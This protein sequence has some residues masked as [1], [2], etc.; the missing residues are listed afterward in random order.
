VTGSEVRKLS[1]EE[2]VKWIGDLRRE[3]DD[4]RV[5]QVTQKIEDNSR[6]GKNRRDLARLLTEQTARR[7]R[8]ETSD[9]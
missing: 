5:Q 8:Q 7:R 4:L 1:D 9:R 3:M 2:I 6:F